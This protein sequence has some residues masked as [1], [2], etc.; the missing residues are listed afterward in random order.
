M[1]RKNS[2]RKPFNLTA[3]G[4]VVLEGKVLL[5]SHKELGKWL[6]PGGHLLCDERCR[7]LESP[8][9]AAIREVKEET[10]FDVEICGKCYAR[11][12]RGHEMLAI[13][14]SA[15]IHRIDEEHD[16]FGSDFFCKIKE[17]QTRT[18][19]EEECRWFSSKELEDY[20][21]D[22]K[23]E[24]NEHVRRMALKAIKRLSKYK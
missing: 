5:V 16:H 3:A 22:G 20:L 13:P 15:H 18:E 4:Y 8:E 9:E 14:E 11:Y 2:C 17:K 12:G 6:P 10:G 19:G 1:L 24:L 21:N 23:L 7:F